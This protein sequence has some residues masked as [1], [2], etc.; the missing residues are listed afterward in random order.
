VST[1][2][3]EVRAYWEWYIENTRIPGEAS[4][5]RGFFESIRVDHEKAYACANQVL[6]LS[7][8]EGKTLLELGC[9]I[10]LDTVQFARHGALVT[11]IDVSSRALE[12]AR[13]NLEYNG[14][15]ATLELGNAEELRF[16]ENSFDVVVARGILMF[17]PD[18]EKVADEVSRVLKP[19][20]SAQFLLHNRFSWYV[21]LGKMSGTK[22]IH[23]EGG[24]P[25]NR[26]YGVR[27]ARK[28]MTSFSSH[29]IAFDRL[30]FETGRAGIAAKLFNRIV[31]PL[32]R[33]IP[34]RI[35]RPF[36]YYMIIT[37]VK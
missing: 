26:L 22:R 33:A 31:V 3:E 17:T 8:L 11:A 7:R 25:V 27:Q 12:L 14:L 4:G 9:G 37:A 29:Q 23:E 18:D 10:G 36:G 15:K 30:P 21:L 5:S 19:G 13:R 1:N 6:R 20:G 28:L 35:L 34:G 24:P 2:I 16:E 32:S